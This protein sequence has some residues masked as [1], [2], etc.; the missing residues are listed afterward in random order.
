MYVLFVGGS[1]VILSIKINYLEWWLRH[2]GWL[3]N[4]W[5]LLGFPEPLS[6]KKVTDSDSYISDPIIH[7]RIHLIERHKLYN[8]EALN[9]T[10]HLPVI[11]AGW[12]SSVS[13]LDEQV[14]KATSSSL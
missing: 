14:E 3:K 4:D 7:P 11:M 12:F 6:E 9:A 10:F 5:E 13:P 1:C 2:Y 8:F